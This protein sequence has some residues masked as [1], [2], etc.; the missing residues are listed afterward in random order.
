LGP[1]AP[2]LE[3]AVPG[4]AVERAVVE[5]VRIV[6]EARL[7]GVFHRGQAASGHVPPLQTQDLQARAAEIGLEDE[8][9]VARAEDDPV[10]VHGCGYGPASASVT[11]PAF[12]DAEYVAQ[13][14]SPSRS[15][16]AR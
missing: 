16:S 2:Q 11:V 14:C 8:A 12:G 1:V 13:A 4:H 3:V 15:I 7:P 6:E 9:V 5:R 10:V